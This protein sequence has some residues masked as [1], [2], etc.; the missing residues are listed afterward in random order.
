MASRLGIVVAIYL[1]MAGGATAQVVR[2]ETTVG[3]FD[4]VLNPTHNAALQGYVDN[5]LNYVDQNRYLGSWINRADKNKDGSD[6]VLQMGGFFSNTKRPPLTIDS[7][8]PVATLAPVK[9]APAAENGLSNT[10]G[11]VALALPG[12]GNGRA[13]AD[14][15][16]SSFF[17]NMGNNSFLDQDFTV[18]ARISDLTVVNNIMDLKTI[19]RSSDPLFGADPN[20]TATFTRVPVQADGLQVLIKRAF[21]VSDALTAAQAIA[22]AGVTSTLTQPIASLSQDGGFLPIASAADLSAPA[23]LVPNVV[24]EPTTL[25]LITAALLTV[26]TFARR[27]R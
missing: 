3:D 5:F 18:F 2:F 12:A 11:T 17:I 1:C 6:F 25:A 13:F 22:A 19:D 15:G 4:M 7:T 23:A 21:V 16:T 8:R 14:E 10:I 20:D 27:R 24:P 9:G 26:A